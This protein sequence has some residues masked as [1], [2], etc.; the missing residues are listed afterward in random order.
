M[1]RSAG[2]EQTVNV[3]FRK[4]HF[5]KLANTAG[6]RCL[7]AASLPNVGHWAGEG[8]LRLPFEPLGNG[9]ALALPVA[10]RLVADPLHRAAVVARILTATVDAVR[11]GP[12]ACLRAVT[13]VP[14]QA[15][16]DVTRQGRNASAAAA[17]LDAPLDGG[18][19]R[20]PPSR[21]APR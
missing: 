17:R 12:Q 5:L 2:R 10:D 1:T 3:N 20:P 16:G 14:T 8:K 6:S 13:A 15:S 7:S 18:N 9:R 11:A 21:S 4:R 19:R